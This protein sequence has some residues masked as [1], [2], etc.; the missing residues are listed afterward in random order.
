MPETITDN[1]W[2]VPPEDNA[3]LARV[4]REA[5]ADRAKLAAMGHRS[6]ELILRNHAPLAVAEKHLALYRSLRLS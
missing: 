3:A 4:L 5:V 2:I 6:R 1:G